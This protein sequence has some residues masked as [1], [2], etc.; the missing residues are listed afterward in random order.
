[1][2]ENFELALKQVLKDEGGNDDDP[3]DHGGRTSR[4]IT[5]REY[6]AWCRLTQKPQGDVWRASDGDIRAIYHD[7]YWRPYCDSLPSGVD[8][9]FFDISVNA[10]RTQAVRT[11]QKALGVKVDGMMGQVTLAAINARDPV[12]LIHAIAEKRRAFYRSLAQFP[13]YGRGWM[14]RVDHCEKISLEMAG[15]NEPEEHTEEPVKIPKAKDQPIA[16]ASVSPETAATASATTGGISSM[17]EQFKETLS[18]FAT[19]IKFI[20]YALIGIA[21]TTFGYAVYGYWKRKK[22]QEAQ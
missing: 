7:Q 21:F 6:N 15:H 18:P 10:G 4:G 11:F 1:M 9:S 3:Q 2:K 22:S 14:R 17:L 20:T 13:R 8:Y 16:E 5:Q 12:K 19:E